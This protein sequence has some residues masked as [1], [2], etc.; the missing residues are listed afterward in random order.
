M[1]GGLLEGWRVGHGRLHRRS[2]RVGGRR[3]AVGRLGRGA[4]VGGL[5]AVEGAVRGRRCP[6]E[7]P[8]WR[9]DSVG[10]WRTLLLLRVLAVVGH[11]GPCQRQGVALA[12]SAQ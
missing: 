1:E 9:T 11:D 10:E 3:N 5:C 6:L 4:G 7:G 12:L 2:W 8:V